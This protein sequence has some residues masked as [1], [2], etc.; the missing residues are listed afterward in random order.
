MS[1]NIEEEQ[2]EYL[3][4]IINSHKNLYKYNVKDIY[5]KLI[6][7]EEAITT[8]PFI[9][10]YELTK[11]IGYR[12]QQIARGAIPLIN[13]ENNEKDIYKIVV[14]EFVEHKTPLIILRRLPNGDKEYIPVTLLKITP[15]LHSTLIF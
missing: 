3:S 1:T 6:T 14:R 13:L 11:I 2:E 5:N 8:S 4:N 10:K 7:N 9:S 12:I 15:Q